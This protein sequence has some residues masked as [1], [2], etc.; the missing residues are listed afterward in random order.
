LSFSNYF[1]GAI[2]FPLDFGLDGQNPVKHIPCNPTW[3]GIYNIGTYNFSTT[4][5]ITRHIK[6]QENMVHSKKK[7]WQKLSLKK[8]RI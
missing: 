1:D 6:K 3:Y 5:K 2:S 8:Y 7:N 4:T